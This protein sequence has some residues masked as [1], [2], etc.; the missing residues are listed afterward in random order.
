[1][2]SIG[3]LVLGQQ[4]YYEQQ[5]AHGGDDYYSGRGETPGEWTGAGTDELG[6]QGHVSAAQF[7]ALLAGADPRNPEVPLRAGNSQPEIAALDLT[8]SA[9]KSVSV[10]FAVAPAETSAALVEAHEQA[11]RAALGY[12]EETAVFVRR[13]KAGQRFEL[14]GGLIA[15]AYRHRMS[16]SLDP[17]LHTHVVAANLARG[18]DGRYTALH[19][20]SLYRA[21][22]TAGYLYQAHLRAELRDR[23]GLEWGP[24]VKG[25]AELRAVPGEVLRTF[26]Q[27]R[28]QVEAVIAEREAELGR[29]LTKAERS[30]WGAIATRDRKQYGIET[31]TWR[32]EMTA[33]AAEHGLDR[34]LVEELLE[35][36][37]ERV[38]RGRLAGEGEL[39]RDGERVG[40][41]ELGTGLAGSVG[42]T[43]RQNTFDEP[44]VLREFAAAAAQGASVNTIR[45]QGGRFADREDVL[46]TQRGTFTTT[47]LVECERT[48]IAAAVERA[49]EGTAQLEQQV[50]EKA[51]AVTERELTREQA[52]A[53][54]AV[55][56]SGNGV[57]VIE[58][59]AGTGKTYTAGALREVCEQAD[60]GVLGVAPSARAARE[61]SEQA[62][63]PARTLDS[64]LLA[65]EGGWQLPACS[66]LVI[67]EAGMASTRQ[68]ARLLEHAAERGVKVVAIGDSGQLPSVLAGGW[69]AAVGQRLGAVRLVEVMRQRDPAER[70][71]LGAM[72]DGI[73]ERWISWA[74]RAGRVEILPEG[75]P[76][77]QQ[78]VAEWAAAVRDHGPEQA[79]MIARENETRR[80]LNELAREHQREVGALGEQCTY[81]PVA[82]AAGDRVI[83]RHNDYDL[84]VDNG[85]RGTVRHVGRGG[86]VLKS[87][88]W[89]V[90][91]LPAG[92]VAEH[93]E[94]AYCLTGHGMQGA[95]VEH[96]TVLAHPHDLSRGWSYTALSRARGTTR[97][98]I[99][100]QPADGA[101]REEIAPGEHRRAG[102]RTGVVAQ[103]A[104]RMRERDDEDLAID[105]LPAAGHVDD[106]HLARTLREQPLEEQAAE[107]A[108]PA[109]PQPAAKERLGHLRRELEGLRARLAALPTSEL[110]QIDQ[111]DARAREL[112]RDRNE[113]RDQ[114][115]QL[116][117]PRR[118]LLGHGNDHGQLLKRTR[119]ASALAGAEEQLERALSD[120]GRLAR[121]IG[122]PDQTRQERDSLQTAIERV[123][124]EHTR[125]R[126][127]LV[128]RELHTRP[129]W[130]TQALG[131]RPERAWE[132][133][134][135]DRAAHAIARYRIEYAITSPEDPL[136]PEPD[137]AGDQRRD[138]QC[139]RQAAARERETPGHDLGLG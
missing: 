70:R 53:V 114:L 137:R 71:A 24:V 95:T 2:L 96:A 48:L 109:Q 25:A 83:C 8:F 99:A 131:E 106:E 127:E 88:A 115:E 89:A 125:L 85:L 54:R 66:V 105:Q 138:F 67:D 79:V 119:V 62:G 18:K 113:L 57:D 15:A 132:A 103:V 64:R 51:L 74:E 23:L 108:E 104:R 61:L 139:A 122:Q 110:S 107:R 97:L 4:R 124:Q 133:E 91:E 80:A 35:H 38:R 55:T 92:Y 30:T 17:Q 123:Q 59:L 77:L 11:V 39:Q 32:Q 121:Q 63:I 29:P 111:L 34:K 118:R 129:Q 86:I 47:D 7:S 73:P 136:G 52:A 94:H 16:R 36:G 101:E 76:A 50:V 37:R 1:M 46:P 126:D 102:D 65:I 42:L 81:G 33:R 22:Q 87:D 27:R 84:G 72:H 100:A 13:G 90:Y 75:Q 134:R 128:G 68:T 26:S 98:L 14:A 116:P 12:L 31:H 60:Y 28:A 58:A 6:L 112:T 3:K 21:A 43:E 10:L 44:A 5:V 120:R 130:L 40:E 9:P 78:A 49:G 56:T 41:D 45:R 93:V 117:A 135:W 19:H 69:L 82:V 20:P